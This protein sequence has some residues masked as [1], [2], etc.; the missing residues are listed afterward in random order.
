MLCCLSS[1]VYIPSKMVYVAR[2]SVGFLF[3]Y[4]FVWVFAF[5]SL[6]FFFQFQL[7]WCLLLFEFYYL[8]HIYLYIC[9]LI[10]VFC[11]ATDSQYICAMRVCMLYVY[12]YGMTAA[13]SSIFFSLLFIIFFNFSSFCSLHCSFEFQWINIVWITKHHPVWKMIAFINGFLGC[14]FRVVCVCVRA[15]AFW[16]FSSQMP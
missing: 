4:L 15:W 9:C 7:V 10:S 2:I 11:T 13:V 3:V 1:S 12:R 5:F 16:G 8:L 6:C 14:L